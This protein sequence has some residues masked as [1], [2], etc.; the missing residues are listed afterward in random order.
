MTDEEFRLTKYVPDGRLEDCGPICR[1]LQ[2]SKI[3]NSAFDSSAKLS[4]DRIPQLRLNGLNVM[5]I[6]VLPSY[7][8]QSEMIF[9]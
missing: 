4:T 8:E 7:F 5:R 1:I 6:T 3:Q 9:L 2:V